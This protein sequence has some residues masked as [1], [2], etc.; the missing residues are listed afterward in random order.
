[1]IQLY[2][3][4][5]LIYTYWDVCHICLFKLLFSNFQPFFSSLR[6]IALNLTFLL[7][8]LKIIIIWSKW[9][10]TTTNRIALSSWSTSAIF[11]SLFVYLLLFIWG[12]NHLNCEYCVVW[13]NLI[14]ICSDALS[15]LKIIQKNRVPSSFYL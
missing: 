8:S 11:I 3:H 13:N 12:K 10:L 6:F 14:C 9:V 4:S 2:Y 1:M 7:R 5:I 15:T